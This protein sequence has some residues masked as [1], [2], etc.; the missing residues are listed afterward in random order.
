MRSSARQVAIATALML[1]SGCGGGNPPADD[2]APEAEVGADVPPGDVPAGPTACSTQ[3]DCLAPGA[4]PPDAKQGC[5]CTPTPQG[6]KQC[7]PA[8]ATS[9]DC[10]KP[11]G[12]TL[13]CGRVG[14]CVPQGG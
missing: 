10:P 1:L 6:G 8:C 11:P 5:T 7:I 9:S 13:V 14:L 3:A 12:Q 4:C 2:D